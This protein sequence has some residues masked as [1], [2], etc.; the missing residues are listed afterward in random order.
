VY[1]V[2]SMT[3]SAMS[4]ELNSRKDSVTNLITPMKNLGINSENGSMLDYKSVSESTK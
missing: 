1:Q 4:S 3:H 2:E